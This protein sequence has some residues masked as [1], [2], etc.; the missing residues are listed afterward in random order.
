LQEIRTPILFITGDK[1]LNSTPSMSKQMANE[2]S[3]GEYIVIKN[4]AHMLAYISPELV[5]LLIED[6]FKKTESTAKGTSI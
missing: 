2:T 3:Y 1:D 4:E 6:F 5:N